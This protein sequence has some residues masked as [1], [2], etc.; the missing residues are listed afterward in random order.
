MTS[1]MRYQVLLASPLIKAC[2]GGVLSIGSLAVRGVVLGEPV[3]PPIASLC[4]LS[5]EL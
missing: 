1:L 2:R 3:M 5:K 4:I